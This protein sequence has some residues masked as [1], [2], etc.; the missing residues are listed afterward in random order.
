MIFFH[1]VLR[2]KN[3]LFILL[4]VLH[5][6]GCAVAV[7]MHELSTPETLE[8][9]AFRFALVSGSAP[10]FI[11][12]SATTT[13]SN[14]AY[15]V[16]LA[17][18]HLG[19][20]LPKSFQINVEAL[21]SGTSMGTSIALKHQFH[22]ANY[23]AAKAGNTA[24]AITLRYWNSVAIDFKVTDVTS[25]ASYSFGDLTAKGYDVT[26][27]YGKRYWDAFAAYL[28]LKVASGDLEAKYKNSS[29][30]TIVASE[31]RSLAGGGAVAGL[32]LGSHSNHVGIDCTLEAELMNLPATL[33]NEK[34]WYSSFMI[35][36]GIPFKF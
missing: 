24:S 18:Y 25:S 28:G 9:W 14:T 33:S 23:F 32:N 12:P 2:M 16:P 8:P 11:T 17:G 22:G 36:V 13:T 19:F 31:S 21:G 1:G 3:Y 10:A 30:G 34:V 6:I 35:M 26:F 5:S 20:G 27:S 29:A 15:S 4:F 7:P